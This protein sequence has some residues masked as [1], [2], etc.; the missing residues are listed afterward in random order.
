MIVEKMK[1]QLYSKG[2]DSLDKVYIVIS[3][4]YING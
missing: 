2:I 1:N 3:V 4:F